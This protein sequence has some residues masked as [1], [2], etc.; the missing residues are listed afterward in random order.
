M[1]SIAPRG[2]AR[3]TV[4][5]SLAVSAAAAAFLYAQ[6]GTVCC[7]PPPHDIP[8]GG[9]DH[10]PPVDAI[11]PADFALRV[12]GGNGSVAPPYHY[13]FEIDVDSAGHGTLRY[14]PGYGQDSSRQVTGRF[15]VDWTTR[16]NWWWIAKELR[17]APGTRPQSEIPVG[18]ASSVVSFTYLTLEKRVDAWQPSPWSAHS[19]RLAA[20]VRAAVPD[21]LWKLAD[22]AQRQ[23]Q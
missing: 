22:D 15:T 1:T 12:A 19:E 11:M 20:A 16:Q 10:L 18:G 6:W 23:L 8:P 2:L 4:L 21:S 14:W 17:D 5:V 9:K 13:D 3:A 7:S